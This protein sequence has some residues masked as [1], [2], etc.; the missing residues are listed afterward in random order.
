MTMIENN[1]WTSIRKWEEFLY[2]CCPECP[3]KHQS[4][5]L[6]I[7]HALK[8]H[9]K[10]K[11][12]LES[13][14]VPVKNEEKE[15]LQRKVETKSSRTLKVL[16]RIKKRKTKQNKQNIKIHDTNET[17]S[18]KAEGFENISVK[19][20]NTADEFSN[21]LTP[22]VVIKTEEASDYENNEQDY[23]FY[24]DLEYYDQDN[25]STSTYDCK[26]CQKSFISAGNLTKHVKSVHEKSNE[27]EKNDQEFSL[28]EDCKYDCKMCKKSFHNIGNLKRHISS[29]HEGK[30]KTLQC[31]ICG[32][33]VTEAYLKIHIQAVHEKFKRWKCKHCEKE[34]AHKEGYLTHVRTIH[35]K[36]KM[37]CDFCEKSFTQSF[38]LREHKTRH[39]E[40]EMNTILE[41]KNLQ[42]KKHQDNDDKQEELKESTSTTFVCNVC[43]KVLHS[44]YILNQ[45]MTF[46]H[47]SRKYAKDGA[48]EIKCQNCDQTFKSNNTLRNHLRVV[49]EGIKNHVCD[50][51]GKAFSSKPNLTSHITYVHKGVRE[52]T[53]TICGNLF[54]DKQVL[55]S[56]IMA[57]HELKKEHTC[58]N[59]GKAFSYAKTLRAHLA[60]IHSIGMRYNC[61]HCG[62]CFGTKYNLD[63]HIGSVH[64]GKKF[65]C[66]FCEKSF[67]QT[68][69][70]GA[71]IKKVHPE[72]YNKN[73]KNNTKNIIQTL[74]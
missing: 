55:K 3:E 35:E 57:V 63:T 10:A 12:C 64:E 37:Q 2:F 8:I 4:K 48:A 43:N 36:I 67:T 18:T 69:V 23:Y 46:I 41:Q 70:L 1:P 24:D 29:V 71:H 22:Q 7:D 54:R 14:E 5:E 47:H 66:S 32:K 31:N 73:R 44:E 68:Q 33:S 45:H 50:S 52:C 34:Y 6:F 59:C 74:S 72:H 56:H 49:H 17:S 58:E 40:D 9:P 62:K 13:I 16:S 61:Q 42:I 25:I 15:E 11:V 38:H 30:K 27:D 53:C 28:D 60:S 51:C 21:K 65:Q 26:L 19:N 20:E 39:H